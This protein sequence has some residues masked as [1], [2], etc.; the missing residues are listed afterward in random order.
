[1]RA[2]RFWREIERKM[3]HRDANRFARPAADPKEGTDH[4]F[5]KNRNFNFASRVTCIYMGGTGCDWMS[6]ETLKYPTAP[7]KCS[8]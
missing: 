8:I 6:V 2:P 4:F 3:V 1:M 5:R 7:S